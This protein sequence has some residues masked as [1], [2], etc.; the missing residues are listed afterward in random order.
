MAA[1]A[2]AV[3]RKGRAETSQGAARCARLHPCSL[4]QLTVQG[5]TALSCS[6]VQLTHAAQCSV[7]CSS[8]MQCCS[9]HSSNVVQLIHAA[10]PGSAACSAA[11]SCSA[12]QLTHPT[13][14]SSL[15]QHGSAQS[16]S[17]VQP[18]HAEQCSSHMQRNTAHQCNTV[19]CP[20]CKACWALGPTRPLQGSLF[21]HEVPREQ[22]AC[23][24]L[25]LIYT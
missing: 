13:W 5:D 16:C 22:L 9:A 12:V 7:Q 20:L 1:A 25:H 19:H 3:P 15:I 14:C 24:R 10:Q 18:N 11:H 4:V 6:V 23:E 21:A 8:L 2:S 17:T